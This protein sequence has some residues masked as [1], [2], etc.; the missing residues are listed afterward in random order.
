MRLNRNIF[1]ILK[2]YFL[3]IVIFSIYRALLFI[4]ETSRVDFD[5]VSTLTIIQSFIMGIRFDIVISGYILFFPAFILLLQD[6]LKLEKYWI[7]HIL[8]YWIFTLFSIAFIISSAD[9]PYFNQFYDRF[10]IGAFE[11]IEN[12]DFVFSMIIQEPKYFL[13]IIP[14]II[15]EIIFFLLL[16]KI[17]NNI[18]QE[19]VKINLYLNIVISLIFLFIMFIGIRGRIQQKSPIRVG[20]AYFSDNSFL[21]KLGLNPVFT[22]MQSYIDSKDNKN[23]VVNLMDKK[24]AIQ[25][26][27]KYLNIKYPQYKSPIA[28]KIVPDTISEIKPNIV[29]IIMESMSAAKMKRHGNKKNL[30][31]FLDSL[32]NNSLYFENIYTS[33]KHTFNGIFSSLFSFP[34]LFRQHTMKQIRKY[35]G[36]SSTLLKLGYSTTYFTTHD[37]QFDNVEGFLR[38]NDFQNIISQS[39]YPMNEIKTTLGVPDDYMFR[40]SIPVINKLYKKD[41]PFF[42]TFMTASDHGP[43]YIPDY[44]HPKSKEIKEQIVEYADWSLRK[45]IHLSSKQEWFDNT[46]FV[47]VADHGAPLNAV[48][49]ISLNYFHTPLIFYAPKVVESNEVRKEIGSQIDIYP[50]IMGLIKQPYIN[51]TLGIDL[52]KERRE[53]A[54]IN[55][56]DKIGIIDSTYFCIM[57]KNSEE[58]TLYKYKQKDKKNYFEQEN[59]QADK[60][61]EY[62]KSTL[63]TYQEM[64]LSREITLHNTQYKKL[65][66]K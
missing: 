5:Q 17:F 36:I 40:Y 24:L 8:F 42:V 1:V 44:F 55:D 49:D 26:V 61:V 22:L 39:N 50:T 20:T 37:S 60:M 21:N 28:R 35:D 15:L 25:N 14:F 52:L 43:Y 59:K 66:R 63:Q 27:Q 53:F 31:P 18:K 23:K 45:F 64:I 56:D 54:I 57:R 7:R 9:I 13:I 47:F 19:H 11:W 4:T 12:F 51:N 30:T 41:K 32:S 33:G 65:G 48:Y 16:K 62:A 29:L 2:T 46:I 6:I 58:L 34:A 38:A 3:V 10:S